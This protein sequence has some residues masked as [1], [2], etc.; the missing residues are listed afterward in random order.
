MLMMPHG[1]FAFTYTHTD[2]RYVLTINI[3]VG[4]HSTVPDT[5]HWYQYGV[6]TFKRITLKIL[7]T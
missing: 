6:V 3:K 2:I 5:K 7:C 1:K 4:A